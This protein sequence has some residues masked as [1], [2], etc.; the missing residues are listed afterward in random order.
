MFKKL[1]IALIAML[2]AGKIAI[3]QQPCGTDKKYWE[4][5]QQNPKI[6]EYEKQFEDQIIAN[7]QYRIPGALGKTT[8]SASDTTTF[9]VPIVIHVVHDYGTENLSDN[10]LYEAAQYWAIVFLAQNSDTAA[11]IPPFKKWIGNSRIRLHLATIDPNGKPTK[12]IVRHNHYLTTNADDGAKFEPWPNNKYINIWF[13]RTFGASATGAAA[14]AYYPA[15]AAGMPFYDG[16]IGLSTYANYAK[17]IPHELGHV[18]NLQHVW[19][20]TNSAGAACGDDHVD[21]TPPTT[22][23]TPVGCVASALYDVACASGYLKHYTA[24]G[25]GDSVVDYPDTVNAQNIMDYTYCQ[26]MFTKGQCVRMRTALTS[27][28]AGRNNLITAAN[29]AST[30]ALA[31]MP[32]LPPVADY[33]MDRGTGGGFV[34]DTRSYFL[35]FNNTNGFVFRNA[36]WNDTV[37]GVK[38]SFSNGATVP[39]STSMTSVVNHFATPGW[40]TV[41]QIATSNAG[42]D[43]LVNTKAVYVADTTAT[44]GVGYVQGFDLANCS[45]WPMINFYNNRFKWEFFNGAS[46]DGDGKCVRYRSF[47][48]TNQQT[49][50]AL[51]DH[52]DFYTPAF[53][54]TDIAGSGNYFLN[55]F[56]SGCKRPGGGTMDSLEI[57]ASITGGT[58]WTR[59]GGVSG[60]TLANITATNAQF[61]PTLPSQW[62]ARAI[63]IPAAY[64]TGNV[65]FRFRYWPG[66]IGNNLYLDNFYIYPYPSEVMDQTADAGIFKIFPNPANSGCNIIFKTGNEGTAAITVKDITGRT[67]YTVSNHYNANGM[68]QETIGRDITQAAGIYFV[69]VVIDGASRTEKL[70]V[71]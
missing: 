57:D 48:T 46:F 45:N 13:V 16:V 62:K 9:D 20:N 7:M 4:L 28:V 41:T 34:S 31:P 11:V 58:Q 64:R 71:Y 26:E 61:T 70:V 67:I 15:S 6:L 52:D 50:M 14:Y 8:L 27:T 39:T 44:H 43:T 35:T 40:V 60:N 66:D 51:G 18:L 42:S 63:N 22:G 65:F 17:A 24:A 30:G 19:G 12:G 37:T 2:C 56:T 69:T 47:D 68:A 32:D 53:N 5:V 29:L 1:S 36:S 33:I 3:A 55:F 54:L 21:D 49:G 59:I 25:G 10:D 23:H 38:W